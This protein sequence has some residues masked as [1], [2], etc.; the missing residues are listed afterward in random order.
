MKKKRRSVQRVEGRAWQFV[1]Q[2][3]LAFA[4]RTTRGYWSLITS[5]K[6]PSLAG[7]ERAVI[8]TLIEPDQ[9][10]ASK[11]D[12]A[13]YLFYRKFGRRHLCVVTKRLDPKTGFVMTA[14]ITDRIK[15]G[16]IVWKR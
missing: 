7:Q 16:R 8:Q 14:Y 12:H 13:V 4:V 9:V 5:V 15:E 6:H 1:V 2:S 3:R 10:R 11:V